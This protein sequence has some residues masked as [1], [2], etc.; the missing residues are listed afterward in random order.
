MSRQIAT[1][2]DVAD[3]AKNQ[4]DAAIAEL[5]QVVN[6]PQLLNQEGKVLKEAIA[7]V[8]STIRYRISINNVCAEFF[9]DQT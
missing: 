5:N 2:A 8:L 6:D 3:K 4:Y 9:R 7:K 1:L